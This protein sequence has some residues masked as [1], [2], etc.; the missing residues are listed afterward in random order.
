ML[1]RVTTRP[2]VQGVAGGFE[3]QPEGLQVVFKGPGL[4]LV[5]HFALAPG[6]VAARFFEFRFEV[7]EKLD[8][9]VTGE[10]RVEDHFDS[11]LLP[12]VTG[13]VPVVWIAAVV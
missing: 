8:L 6:K 2:P 7:L 13:N 9:G 4:W 3:L 1:L 10:V 5:G 11:T 12:R